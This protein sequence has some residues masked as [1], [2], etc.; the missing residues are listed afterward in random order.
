MTWAAAL[1][2]AA[3]RL[4]RLGDVLGSDFRSNAIEV[5]AEREGVVVEGFAALRR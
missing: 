4:A 3:G 1:P 5:R 2:G